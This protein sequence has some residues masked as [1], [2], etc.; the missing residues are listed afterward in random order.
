MN[1]RWALVLLAAA[2]VTCGTVLRW[3]LDRELGRPDPTRFDRRPAPAAG[4]VSFERQVRPLL[5]RR[6]VVCHACYDA[7]CQLKLTSWDGIARG[8][9]KR[10]VYKTR[11]RAAP[12]TRLYEDA[13]SPS[14]WRKLEFFPVLNEREQ[15]PAAN[16]TGGLIYQ[17]LAQKRR[18]PTPASGPLPPSFELSLGAER[19]CP[20]IEE[21]AGYEK[22][23]PL[24][25][26]PYGMPPLDDAEH[27]VLERWLAAGRPRRAARALAPGDRRAGP[28][29]G[30]VLQRRFEQAPPGRPL[31]VRAPVPRAPALRGRSRAALLPPGPVADAAGH[32]RR[33]HRHPAS[34]R[35]PGCA[36]RV[37]PPGRRSRDRGRQ[38]PHALRDRRG[39]P[40]ALARAVHA[41][42]LRGGGLAPQR[43]RRRRRTRS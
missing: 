21:H 16:L 33:P 18:H 12:P 39:A 5:E 20:R 4:G 29:L 15:A 8:G 32:P 17:M 11:L 30:G 43:R 31:P 41:A 36:A 2:T 9:S 42:E 35:R 38:D 34:V 7:P 3:D 22:D 25:G 28:P 1:R 13:R 40:A 37:L 23:H 27:A 24:W 19:K 14:A 6:C 10:S 26:M